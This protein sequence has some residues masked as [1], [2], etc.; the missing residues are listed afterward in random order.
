MYTLEQIEIIWQKAR[1]LYYRLVEG[2]K[3]NG[4][5]RNTDFFEF[6][7]TDNLD[8][9]TRMAQSTALWERFTSFL[10]TLNDGYYTVIIQANKTAS[11]SAAPYKF[12]KGDVSSLPA[13]N[14][15]V[16]SSFGRQHTEG[17]NWGMHTGAQSPMMLMMQLM[18][19]Q[20]A[21]QMA[22]MQQSNAQQTAMMQTLFQK[23]MEIHKMGQ[24][25]NVGDK[26]VGLLEK[27]HVWNFL[28]QLAPGKAVAIGRAQA[29]VNE[30]VPRPS[31]VE[32]HT[33]APPTA[34]VN[35]LKTLLEKVAAANPGEDPV[36]VLSEGFDK[37]QAFLAMQGN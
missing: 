19:Q 10:D 6:K 5:H 2:E 26:L 27:P 8:D 9:A 20:N 36:Q 22:M 1:P 25:K 24:S 16:G 11:A 14:S 3:A 35:Q 31:E 15:A 33:D 37:V 4:L 7:K 21:Q 18:Q 34:Q 17:G 13:P 29:A 28:G 23:D 30:S 32:T 12:A